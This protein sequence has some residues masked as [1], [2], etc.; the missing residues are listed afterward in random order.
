MMIKDLVFLL[1]YFYK[2]NCWSV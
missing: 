2:W 1:L